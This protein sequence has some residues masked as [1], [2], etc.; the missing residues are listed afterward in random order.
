VNNPSLDIAMIQEKCSFSK[1]PFSSY[2]QLK[3]MG[4]KILDMNLKDEK[5]EFLD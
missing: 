3:S 1:A 5:P 4:V 2:D